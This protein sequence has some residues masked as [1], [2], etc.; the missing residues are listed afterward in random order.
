MDVALGQGISIGPLARR[1]IAGAEPVMK[2]GADTETDRVA[3]FLATF[4]PYALAS[5]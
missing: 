3:P 1:Q 5:W 4:C 2:G